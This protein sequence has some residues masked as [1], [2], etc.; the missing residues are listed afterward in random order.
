[1]EYEKGKGDIKSKQMN[2][3]KGGDVNEKGCGG[4]GN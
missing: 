2:I 3:K 1:V 4:D